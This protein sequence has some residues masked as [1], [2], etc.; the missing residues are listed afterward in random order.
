MSTEDVASA[1]SPPGESAGADESARS[2]FDSRY[3]ALSVGVITTVSVVA[4]ES[5]G[6]ATVLPVVARDLDGLGS[7]GWGL[8]ALMLANI[9]GAVVAGRVADRGGPWVPFAAS[10]AVFVAGCLLAAASP[11]WLV[12]LAG[13]AVQGFGVGGVMAIAF[14]SIGATYPDHLQPRMYALLSSAWS[15][16]ALAGPPIGGLVAETIGWPWVFVII[17]PIAVVAALL[18]TPAMRRLVESGAPSE[19]PRG[20]RDN[21]V[22]NSVLLTA[23][24]AVLLLAL[25]AGSALVVVVGVVVGLLIA[26]VGLRHVTPP[27]TLVA[28][29]GVASGIV[30]RAGLCGAY[31]G[32]EAFLPLGMAEL[33]G[34][35]T[36]LSGIGLAVGALTWV[37]G[38]FW[39]AKVDGGTTRDRSRATALGSLILAV[40]A[41][42]V[43]VA[44]LVP[45]VPAVLAVVGWGIG[46]L[47]MGVAVNASTSETMRLSPPESLGLTSSSL[48][49]AQ[50]LATALI[51]GLGGGLISL[52]TAGGGTVATALLIT[53]AVTVVIAL[54]SVVAAGRFRTGSEEAA[55]ASANA[56]A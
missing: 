47:G 44:I 6:V 38:S 9:V 25:E 22:L 27:G 37:G 32:T 33:R 11:S 53:F 7:F 49:L 4:F 50:T 34:V 31:F 21:V 54:G 30:V 40:G 45:A 36:T 19:A 10:I 35:G 55:P 39:Q 18:A 28:R 46:G 2:V 26:G 12:F 42:V 3:R 13:R 14:M 17:V 29:R 1:T 41:V 20:W 24:T 15:I 43:A 56:V 52:V 16:P 23:G 5:L 8:S 48:Q 51:A